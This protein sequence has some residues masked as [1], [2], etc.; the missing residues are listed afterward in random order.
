MNPDGFHIQCERLIVG[1]S[2]FL[3]VLGSQPAI[4]KNHETRSDS[5]VEPDS[6]LQFH[7]AGIELSHLGIQDSETVM[8]G[9]ILRVCA[10]QRFVSL[11]CLLKI[12]ERV[13]VSGCDRQ[14]FTIASA[15]SL[16][17]SV[18]GVIAESF[19]FE[20]VDV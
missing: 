2:R 9:S 8:R 11:R 10:I 18:P 4:A 3:K 15:A 16:L 20:S 17:K 1:S 5:G 19:A 12:A 14:L 13:I 7:N 6:L